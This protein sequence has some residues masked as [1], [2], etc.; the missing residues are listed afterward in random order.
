[1][2]EF[3]LEQLSSQHTSLKKQFNCHHK[4]PTNS[5]LKHHKRIDSDSRLTLRELQNNRD[6]RSQ[7]HTHTS[8]HN[9]ENCERKESVSV[10]SHHN[11]CT[12]TKR[13]Q[14]K[15]QILM[16]IYFPSSICDFFDESKSAEKMVSKNTLR[17][18]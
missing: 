17:Y 13:V 10:S 7:D 6:G 11:S 2:T 18:F 12:S 15:S 3:H 14:F 4:Q 8:F 9:K 16:H 1:M 5:I